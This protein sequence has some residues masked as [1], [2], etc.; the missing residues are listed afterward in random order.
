MP[1]YLCHGFRW[2]RRNIRVFV[3]IND[4]GDAAPD[5]IASRTTSSLILK[6][7]YAQFDFLPS[8]DALK[9]P[10]STLPQGPQFANPQHK[11]VDF[12]LPP[13]RSEGSSSSIATAS[14]VKLLEEYDPLEEKEPSRPYAFVA[15]HVVRVDLSA[16]VL[17][18]MD[19]YERLVKE[20]GGSQWFNKLRDN[21]QSDAEIRWYLVVCGDEERAIA[22]SDYSSGGEEEARSDQGGEGVA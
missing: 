20:R 2:H 13:P 19:A 10:S 17:V 16:D 14:A 11:E 15:D 18:E 21:L 12:T 1:T 5:W 22:E 8:H 9:A 4:L 7:L 3:I 6:Q